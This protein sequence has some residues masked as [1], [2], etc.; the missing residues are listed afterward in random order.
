MVVRMGAIGVGGI[1]QLELHF[2]DELEDIN[3][4]AAA[5]VAPGACAVFETEF[6][7]PA[8]EDYRTL[9]ETHGN[10]LD[11]ILIATPHSL[12]YEQAKA[13]LEEDIHVLLEKPLTID[14]RDAI[15]LVQTANRRNRVL[16]VGYQRH[17]HPVFRAMRH[18]IDSGRIGDIHTISAHIGQDW[19]APHQGT[20]RVDPDRSGGGQLYD[21]GSHLLDAVVWVTQGT[22]DTV[23]A[24]IEYAV[25]DIDVSAALTTRLTCDEQSAVASIAVTGN[26]TT[27]DPLEGYVI[28]GTH[29][30]LVFTGE[31]LYVEHQGATR[32][33]IEID[34][35]FDLITRRK[36]YNFV[37][38]IIGRAKPEA[39][40]KESIPVIALTEAAYT[41]ADE[42]R[43]IDVQEQIADAEVLLD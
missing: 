18:I 26:G 38:S 16:Q 41:A 9:L 23:T 32:Y 1:G 7:A 43:T 36:V 21:T 5:D 24:S 15:D 22:P 33:H 30:T 11:G 13:C 19:Y 40:A 27:M 34:S 3:I 8:Y 37:N 42:E 2:L 20:W 28:W 31:D 25:P 10:E 29:G 39:P 12:H 6:D 35:N 17:Y 4:I 14:V